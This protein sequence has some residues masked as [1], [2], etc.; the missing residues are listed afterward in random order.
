M[1]LGTCEI[2]LRLMI[3]KA[4]R[5]K[6]TSWRKRSAYNNSAFNTRSINNNCL[7][8]YLNAQRG[9]AESQSNF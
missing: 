6:Y 5:A 9:N 8:L 2:V 7:R 1:S 3:Y 4:V